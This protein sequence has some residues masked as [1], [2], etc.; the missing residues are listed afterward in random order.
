MIKKYFIL[1][2]DLLGILY[3]FSYN[4]PN[5]LIFIKKNKIINDIQINWY[6]M[7]ID[8]Y[9]S[10]EFIILFENKIKWNLISQF[11]YL[12]ELILYKYH[13]KLNWK[14]VS[15]YQYLSIDFIK[16]NL[17]LIDLKSLLS[18]ENYPEGYILEI[19]RK[20]DLERKVLKM[21]KSKK[22]YKKLIYMFDSLI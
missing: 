7:C 4:N 14:Y 10:F 6:D 16:E 8:E 11:F 20:D 22:R 3:N 2:K 15:K 1:P 13:D 9:I 5:Y 12:D 17:D 21:L 18:N 19:I